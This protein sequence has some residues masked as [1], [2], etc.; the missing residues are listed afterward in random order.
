M[1]SIKP[2]DLHILLV[3]D[4]EDLLDI[5]QVELEELEYKVTTCLDSQSAMGII[6][7]DKIDLVLSDVN[8]PAMDGLKLLKTIKDKNPDL[9]VVLFMTGYTEYKE[10]DLIAQGAEALFIKPV[11]CEKFSKLV[12]E[13]FSQRKSA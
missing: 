1:S 3:D 9:P 10:K 11:D 2:S 7:K 8:M 4:E 5:I 13:L 12:L 6:E